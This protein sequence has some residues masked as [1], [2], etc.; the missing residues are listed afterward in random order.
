MGEDLNT[1]I[2]RYEKALAAIE[3][4][5][6]KIITENMSEKAQAGLTMII[7]MARYRV[8]IRE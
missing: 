1:K 7:S 3:D 8:D 2:D 4:E 5:A 6:M